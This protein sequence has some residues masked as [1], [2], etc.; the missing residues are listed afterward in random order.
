MDPPELASK[1]PR[2]RIGAASNS[3]PELRVLG[4]VMLGPF[5]CTPL[6]AWTLGLITHCMTSHL[7]PKQIRVNV[8]YIFYYNRRSGPKHE[9]P[10]LGVCIVNV[11]LHLQAD[12]GAWRMLLKCLLFLLISQTCRIKLYYI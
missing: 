6:H 12:V 9:R 7:L 1:P 3:A 4:W 2:S 5:H 10:F 11:L 8:C